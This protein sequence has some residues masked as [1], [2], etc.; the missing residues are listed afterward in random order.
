M[1]RYLTR[2]ATIRLH[3]AVCRGSRRE[4]LAALRFQR[5]VTR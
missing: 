1:N 2:I 5:R 3:R 4:I